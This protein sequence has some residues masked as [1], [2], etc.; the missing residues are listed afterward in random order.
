M[1]RPWFFATDIDTSLGVAHR[2]NCVFW[3]NGL[4]VCFSVTLGEAPEV[5]RW[6][7]ACQRVERVF[8]EVESPE[9]EIFT[10]EDERL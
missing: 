3:G 4:K 1:C 6:W 2:P 5:A 9:V 10:A 8:S 7:V